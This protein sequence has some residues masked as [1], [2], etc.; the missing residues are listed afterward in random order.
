MKQILFVDDEPRILEGFRRMLHHERGVWEMTFAESGDAAWS[1]MQETPFDVVVSDV[2]M[3]GITGFTLLERI[4]GSAELA[5][6]PVIIVSGSSEEGLKK[7]ALEL[8]ATD[9]LNKPINREEL[10][11][12]LRNSIRLKE[13]RDQIK[14]HQQELEAKVDERT[15]QLYDSRVE[16]IL[17]LAKASEYRDEETG[18]HVVRVGL[19]CRIIAQAMNLD[20][21]FI[22]QLF[23]A[24]PLHDLG[25]IGI[26]DSVLLKP[27]KLTGEE[28]D[29]MKRH[30][31]IGAQI[32]REDC[33]V[34]AAFVKRETDETLR[35]DGNP[36][37]QMASRIALTHHEKWDGSGYP[38]GLSGEEIPLESRIVAIADVYDALRSSRPYKVAFSEEK[39][40][41]II[42][43]G[44]G[45]H[46]DPAVY[47]AFRRSLGAIR[48]V[49]SRF[50]DIQTNSEQV[51]A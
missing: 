13:C 46:F 20:E 47:E 29:I 27:G 10:V 51:A 12:R 16:I 43:E 41:E 7:Q 25:K 31:E 48:A 33:K 5:D 1:L 2:F 26:P 18:N 19:Y 9:L 14:A 35:F 28:W 44:A 4:L 49:E 21:A 6:T 15:R 34:M 23:L 3:S 11:A 42:S 32:L 17:R 39:A 38:N 50:T 45:K 8:G 24:S 30:C 36:F 22:E 40:L 37:L